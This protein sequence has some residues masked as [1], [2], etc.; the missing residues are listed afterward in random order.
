MQTYDAF[1]FMLHDTVLRW[2]S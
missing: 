2:R 1:L